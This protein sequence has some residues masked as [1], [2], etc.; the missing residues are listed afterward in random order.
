MAAVPVETAEYSFIFRRLAKFLGV[1]HPNSAEGDALVD[2]AL[3]TE[4]FLEDQIEQSDKEVCLLIASIEDHPYR[5]TFF[6]ETNQPVE[7]EAGK[8]IPAYEGVHGGIDIRYTVL[9]DSDE[10]VQYEKPG[11]LAQ[12]FAHLLRTREKSENYPH[13]VT[14]SAKR[15][16]WI[17]NGVL[18][19]ADTTFV[20][21]VTLPILNL[22]AFAAVGEGEIPADAAPTLFTPKSLQNALLAHAMATLIPMGGDSALINAWSNVWLKAEQ[23]IKGKN[24]N[25]PD[26]EHLQRLGA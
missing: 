16:Y 8:R 2:H 11:E 14:A 26:P 24:L 15:L 25:I 12:N 10:P 3:Y 23:M 22:G 1:A 18:E 7:V 17:E 20:G 9:D 6:P 4:D 5:N 21:L 19:L 13:L